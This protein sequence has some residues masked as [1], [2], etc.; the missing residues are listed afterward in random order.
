[1]DDDPQVLEI[2]STLLEEAGYEVDRAENALAAIAAIVRSPPDL[3]LSDIRMPIV[4]GMGLVRELKAHIDSREIPAVAFTGYDSPEMREAAL[5][6]GYDDYIPKLT[7]PGQTLDRIA[8]VIRQFK[9][10]GK[11]GTRKSAAAPGAGMPAPH[12]RRNGPP[13]QHQA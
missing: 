11:I 1:M 13:E 7:E 6:A 8:A 9:A 3:V 10:K 4:G 2:F 5:K 12:A